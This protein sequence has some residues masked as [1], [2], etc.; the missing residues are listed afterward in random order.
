[1]ILDQRGLFCYCCAEAFGYGNNQESSTCPAA[2]ISW[3]VLAKISA[4]FTE[5]INDAL[6]RFP[7]LIQQL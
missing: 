1:L 4:L 2:I 3:T 6:G 5:I 7:R